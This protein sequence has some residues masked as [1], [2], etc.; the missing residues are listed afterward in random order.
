MHDAPGSVRVIDK[1]R[2]LAAAGE[3]LTLDDEGRAEI[4]AVH[5]ADAARILLDATEPVA[6]VAAETLTVAQVAALA[7]GEDPA[8][9]AQPRCRF[10]SP[11]AYEHDVAGYLA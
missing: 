7:R 8:A 1:F 9:V 6:N 3:T 4:G 2:G 10:L 5:V 11:S